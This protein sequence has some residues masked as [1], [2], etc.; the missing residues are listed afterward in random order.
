MKTSTA[1]LIVGGAAVV[2][3]LG[4]LWWQESQRKQVIIGGSKNGRTI[5]QVAEDFVRQNGTAGCRAYLASNGVVNDY[6]ACSTAGRIVGDVAGGAVG[7]VVNVIESG[8]DAFKGL[9]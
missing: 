6:G 7:G 4:Y 9:F 8:W 2:G 3:G 1:L 5:E